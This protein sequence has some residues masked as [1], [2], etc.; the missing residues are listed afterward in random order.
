MTPF[1]WMY[2][3][4]HILFG[5]VGSLQLLKNGLKLAFQAPITKHSEKPEVFYGLVRE[6]SPKPRLEMFQRKNHEGFEGWGN[7]ATQ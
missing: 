3:T 4:E 7:E 2:N 5:R 1:S 6:V